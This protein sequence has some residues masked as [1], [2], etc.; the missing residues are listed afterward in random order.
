MIKKILKSV[1][2]LGLVLA[3]AGTATKAWFTSTVTAADNEITTGTLMLAIDS[4]RTHTYSGLWNGGSGSYGTPFD[5][6]NAVRDLD[7]VSDDREDFEPWVNAEPGVYVAYSGGSGVETLPDGNYSVWIAVRN[8][9]TLPLNYRFKTT[10]NWVA[11]SGRLGDGE[12]IS[13][14]NANLVEVKNVHRYGNLSHNPDSGCE[15]D[16]ECRNLRDALVDLN[17]GWTPA[18]TS[19]ANFS[20][21]VWV[22]DNVTLNEKEFVIYR[23]DMNLSEN[24]GNC[25][26]GATYQYDLIGQAKQVTASSFQVLCLY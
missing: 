16:E 2:V 4:T 7:G 23:L 14:G 11:D 6:Y 9:G 19:V 8:R 10:G 1:L 15:N 5:A 20:D 22:N 26:Q 17:T 25:Y 13:S 21:P 24:A 18:S 12:C 3:T